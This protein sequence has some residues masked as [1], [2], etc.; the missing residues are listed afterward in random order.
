MAMIYSHK[1]D[2]RR[3]NLSREEKRKLRKLLFTKPTA[4]MIDK[5][6]AVG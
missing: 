2:A 1:T 4:W 5:K 3:R 6:T